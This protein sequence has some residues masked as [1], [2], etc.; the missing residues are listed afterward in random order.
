M[1]RPTKWKRLGWLSASGFAVVICLLISAERSLSQ[2]HPVSQ[3]KLVEGAKREGKMVWYS[4]L[5]INDSKALLDRFE[6]KYPFIKTEL[7]RAG[8]EQ[9]LNRVLNEDRAGRNLFD[10]VNLTS[11][12]ALKKAGLL[13]P[14][15]SREGS[16]YPNQFR[17]P[18]GYWVTLYN[19]YTVIGYN[20]KLVTQGEA[21]RQWENL[22]D[23][24]WKGKIGMDQ[25]EYEWYAGMLD[26]WGREKGGK[27][28]RALSRQG[29]HWRK[30]HTLI[31]QLMA[32]G[33]FS[34]GLVYAHRIESMKR[35]G[36]APVEWVKSSDPITVTLAPIGVAAK[37]PHPNAAKL[38]MDFSL[39]KEAQAML[40][41]VNRISGRQDIEPIV[42]EMHP[43]KLRLVAIHPG[44]A[45]ELAR[46]SKE[47][48]DIFSR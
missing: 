6:Q 22:L 3:E 20:T 1:I 5:N 27:F 17:D 35:G 41:K 16:A 25:E 10:A 19:L 13:Q 11:I 31:A 44:V 29:I 7:F 24:K 12:T 9:L 39:S 15:R 2:T 32:A 4:S 14:H 42:P 48:Q 40:Q 45:E 36:G 26:Y 37:A 47:F 23:P 46:Y 33:E 8:A 38:F 34:V 30:G 18:D 28:M 21:P 43:G